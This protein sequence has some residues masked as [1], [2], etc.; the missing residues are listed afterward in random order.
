MGEPPKKNPGY[1]LVT[2]D[3]RQ[4]TVATPD[5]KEHTRSRLRR[6][7]D[8]PRSPPDHSRIRLKQHLDHPRSQ[9]SYPR[10]PQKSPRSRGITNQPY[11]TIPR[12]RASDPTS[13]QITDKLPQ[14]TPD[15]PQNTLDHEQSH[16]RPR[17]PPE[18]PDLGQAIP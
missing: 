16:F 18:E 13:R 11:Q 1:C 6:F 2:R 14:I 7:P 9:R 4:I 17:Q 10:S 8:G 15:S 12:S 5:P 3:I